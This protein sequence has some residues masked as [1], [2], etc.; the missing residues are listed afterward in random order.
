MPVARSRPRLA[1]LL[2]LSVLAGCASTDRHGGSAPTS[3]VASDGPPQHLSAAD[4]A[5][6]RS[7][8][9]P[10]P[11]DEPLSD[12]GNPREYVV[13]GK[14][15][16]TSNTA[17]GYVAEGT[18]SWYG[19]KFHGR[20]TSSGEP[21]DMFALTAAHR[22]LPLPTYLLVT[23]LANGKQTIVRVND[24][25]PFHDDRL[26]DLSY[27]AAVKL[28]FSEN[29]TAPVRLQALTGG[30]VA[31]TT[32]PPAP[33]DEPALVTAQSIAPLAAQPAQSTNEVYFVQAGAFAT[34]SGAEALRDRLRGLL[35]GGEPVSIFEA[36]GW[37]RVRVGPLPTP[38]AATMVQWDLRRASLPKALVLAEPAGSCQTT[39]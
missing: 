21:F 33:P 25:G 3:G 30:L 37:Y 23:N 9:D 22:A 6:L 36:N 31:G 18:A 8:P 11:R 34:E 19:R 14:R 2:A 7:Q 4:L 27:G 35:P 28:G 16:R 13:L 29:G 1:V 10:I 5:R 38:E 20:L 26:L 39:C 12:R 32:A 17:A 24:R 15:Y